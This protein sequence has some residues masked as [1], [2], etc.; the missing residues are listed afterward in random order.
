MRDKSILP[1]LSERSNNRKSSLPFNVLDSIPEMEDGSQSE[2]SI[3]SACGTVQLKEHDKEEFKHSEVVRKWRSLPTD[4]T[5]PKLDNASS[6]APGLNR[7]IGS[8]NSSS[9]LNIANMSLSPRG[10][11]DKLKRENEIKCSNYILFEPII[12]EQVSAGSHLSRYAFR[13]SLERV[14]ETDGERLQS[15]HSKTKSNSAEKTTRASTKREKNKQVRSV[16]NVDLF[17]QQRQQ[18]ARKGPKIRV[19]FSYKQKDSAPDSSTKTLKDSPRKSRQLELSEELT[20]PRII[21]Y[22]WEVHEEK[23]KF[24]KVP[25]PL[26]QQ[27][28]FP[29]LHRIPT[30]LQEDQPIEGSSKDDLQDNY[31]RCD[32]PL[33]KLPQAPPPTPLR[34]RRPSGSSEKVPS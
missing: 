13:S 5:L 11:S 29:K 2:N 19:W 18:L 28:K 21:L 3:P 1:H 15:A 7:G 14:P 31:V 20:F 10:N 34:Q 4:I 12:A 8:P 25:R 32:S 24:I 23:P 30:A 22:Q 6:T 17:D 9:F 33:P 27:N 16:K 26:K